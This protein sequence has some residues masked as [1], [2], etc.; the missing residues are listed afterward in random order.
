MIE[1]KTMFTILKHSLEKW[2]FLFLNSWNMETIK[3]KISL[4]PD[5]NQWPKDVCLDSTVHNTLYYLSPLQ[6]SALPT[7]LSRDDYFNVNN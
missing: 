7:E 1:K 5:L 6:S 4:E 3:K 2:T